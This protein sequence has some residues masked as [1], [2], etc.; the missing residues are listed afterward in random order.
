MSR[1]RLSDQGSGFRVQG[2]GFRIKGSGFR[3][4]GTGRERVEEVGESEAIEGPVPLEPPCLR[5]RVLL[6]ACTSPLSDGSLEQ[7]PTCLKHVGSTHLVQDIMFQGLWFKRL[8]DGRE[9]RRSV[10]RR[11][12]SD[13][14]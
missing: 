10:S 8:P 2:S 6:P 3:V 5:K 9:W 12:L 14:V 1:R 4:Q 11:R 13:L 7:L